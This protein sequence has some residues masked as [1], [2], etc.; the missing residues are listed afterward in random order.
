MS[1]LKTLFFALVLSS[2]PLMADAHDLELIAS[3]GSTG[4]NLP[5]LS[6]LTNISPQIS[7]NGDIA[8]FVMTVLDGTY[9][10]GIYTQLAGEKE[11]KISRLM[12]REHYITTLSLNDH[13][14]ILL[15]THDGGS[16]LGLY[17]YDYRQNIFERAT[18]WDSSIFAMSSASI[19]NNG[20]M[21]YRMIKDTKSFG[22]REIILDDG[23]VKQSLLK[24]GH[25]NISYIFSPKLKG[26]YGVV[27]VRYGK[28]G[29]VGEEQPDKLWLINIKTKRFTP[30]ALDKDAMPS[31]KL[32]RIGNFYNIS[33]NGRYVFWASTVQG[34]VLYRLGDNGI[35]KPILREGVDFKKV[36][37]FHPSV[38]NR[39]EVVIRGTNNQGVQVISVYRDGEWKDVAKEGDEVSLF[40]G[41]YRIEKRRGLTYVG[42]PSINNKSQV[43]FNANILNVESGEKQEAIFKID[44]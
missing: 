16:S 2:M 22:A 30:I 31:S 23:K 11:G 26:Q 4:Q 35:V 12:P 37:L 32:T 24:E 42:Q 43:V 19:N 18:S 36:D 38:N 27:K 28:I 3:T 29:Q 34:R 15:G 9:Y 8:F 1:K 6:Y 41:S 40:A 44:L 39:G 20:D 5:T 17:K 10:H 21:L 33:E 7:N 25:G 13:N 14:E